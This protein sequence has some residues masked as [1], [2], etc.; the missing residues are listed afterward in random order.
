MRLAG[1]IPFHPAQK[2]SS[3]IKMIK[4]ICIDN[5]KSLV[6]FRLDLAKFSCLVGLNGSGKSTVLHALDFLSRQMSG[7]LDQWLAERQW[8][9]RDIN[10][11][12][13]AKS[14]IDFKV[15]VEDENFGTIVWSGS[16][17][18]DGL[19]CTRED[20]KLQSREGVNCLKVEDGI[21][22]ISGVTENGSDR[23]SKSAG[24][25]GS[26]S[27]S[28][29]F[30]IRFDYQGS[31]VSQLKASQLTDEI[32]AL[33]NVVAG[34]KSLDL[35]APEFLRA[36]TKT[37]EI[38]Y[39]KGKMGLGG[40]RFSAYIHES[41]EEGKAALKDRLSDV[42]PE[43]E[44]IETKALQGGAKQLA[45]HER[46]NGK[47]LETPAR[48]VNDGLLRFMAMFSQIDTGSE[49]LLFDEVENGVN[50]ELIEF[51]LDS[52]VESKH[53]VLVTS[54]SPMILNFLDDEIAQQGVVYL[55]RTKE[56]HTKAIKLFDIP[57][58]KEKL[59]IMG[60]GE[61]YIDTHL[62]KREDI[63]QLLRAG[64]IDVSRIDMNSFNA[65]KK[66]L[67]EAVESATG[68]RS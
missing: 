68:P 44:R 32:R 41:G 61:A 1:N 33:R 39:H 48:H 57:S 2:Q 53:Q 16:F 63:N 22:T 45:I 54:H 19:R 29:R 3:D 31:I 8:D 64:T 6:G 52:L 35:L 50:P 21:C 40:Q 59:G 20:I 30:P 9:I 13:T 26:K 27:P 49:F 34:I 43:L 65:F 60:P 42:Y 62:T 17:N 25:N 38:I 51:M 47:T 24:A 14:N 56:G 10:S 28:D 7:D 55:Y 11:K 37:A 36:N 66:D 67:Q 12:F 46:F 23:A 4:S 15:V 18:R 58:M 5:F